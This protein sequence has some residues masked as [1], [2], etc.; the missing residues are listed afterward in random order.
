V[1]IVDRKVT[2]SDESLYKCFLGSDMVEEVKKQLK[3]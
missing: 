3:W 1:V 2:V